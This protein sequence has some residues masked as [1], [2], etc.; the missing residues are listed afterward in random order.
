MI[1]T[2]VCE[3][4]RSECISL[5]PVQS[6][7]KDLGQRTEMLDKNVHEYCM[8]HLP[9]QERQPGFSDQGKGQRD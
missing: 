2:V 4:Q 5:F 7:L 8:N 6:A 1:P 9:L 3:G